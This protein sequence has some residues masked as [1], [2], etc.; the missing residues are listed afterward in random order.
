MQSGNV[1]S[2]IVLVNNTETSTF[3]FSGVGNVSATVSDLTS[4]SYYCISVIAV[5]GHLLSEEAHLCNYTGKL[6]SVYSNFVFKLTMLT[7]ETLSC[8]TVK[9]T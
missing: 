5:S 3:D 9:T 4:G 7:V 1:S 6:S 2:Y 8:F